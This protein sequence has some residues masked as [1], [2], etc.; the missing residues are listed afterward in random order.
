MADEPTWICCV[1]CSDVTYRIARGSI[2]RTC[3]GCGK[4]VWVSPSGVT[5][6]QERGAVPMCM[7]CVDQH[8]EDDPDDLTIM[9]L[10]PEQI[11]EVMEDAVEM[12]RKSARNN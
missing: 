11:T 4:G 8:A 12:M 6:I 7:R 3:R 1:P 9:P 10:T 5:I 2:I